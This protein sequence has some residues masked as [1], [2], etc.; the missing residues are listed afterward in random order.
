[1]IIMPRCVPSESRTHVF[2]N[3]IFGNQTL[4]RFRQREKL[5]P[6]SRSNESKDKRGRDASRPAEIPPKGWY[7]ILR[8]IKDEQSKDHLSIIAAGMAFYWFLAI[9]PALAAG[10]SIYGLAADPQRLKRQI[11]ALSGVMPPQAYKILQDQLTTVL[12][13]SGGALSLGLIGGILLA[14]W[15]AN[16]GAKALISALNVVYDEEE[17]RGVFKLNTVSL[18]ITFCTVFL[19]TVAITLVIAVPALIGKL[20][21]P[22]TIQVLL[23]YLRWPLLGIFLIIGLAAAYRLCPDRDS[24]RWRWVSWGSVSATLLWLLVSWLFSAYVANFG[25]YSK[26]YG[27]MGAVVILLMWF[28]LTSYTILLGAELNAEMEHQTQKDS[29][30]GQSEPMGSREAHVADTAGKTHSS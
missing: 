26:I 5:M 6:A 18:L 8:R 30:V 3:P 9:F 17:K 1:M 2:Q 14:L 15:S 22:A 7:D 29:T 4:K 16:N 25:G 19:G 21:L 10:V 27:S 11:D 20:D 23:T 24:P 13:H 28:F 12:Q